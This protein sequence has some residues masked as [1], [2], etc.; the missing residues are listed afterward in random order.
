M[1]LFFHAIIPSLL[2]SLQ[3]LHAETFDIPNADFEADGEGWAIAAGGEVVPA[4]VTKNKDIA[5]HALSLPAGAFANVFLDIIPAKGTNYIATATLV[6]T[7]AALPSNGKLA[8]F[9]YRGGDSRYVAEAP[10]VWPGGNTPLVIRAEY[11]CAAEPE[12][13]WK[14]GVQILAQDRG[15]IAD[16]VHLESQPT[17]EPIRLEGKFG[18]IEV[19]PK[20]PAVRSLTLRREDGTLEPHSLFSPK[21]EPWQRGMMEWGTQA[22]TF[23]VD[24]AGKRFESRNSAPESVEKTDSSITLRGIVLSD[25][26]GEPVA[27][28]N[29]VLKT[30]GENFSWS[31]ERTW[32]RDMS[33]TSTGSP[34]LFFS[35]RP[36]SPSPSTIL[37]NSV[38]TSFWIN[39]NKLT[40]W[41]NPF[42]RS[43]AQPP[44]CKMSLTNNMVMTEPGGWAVLKLFPAWQNVTEPKFSAEAGHLYRRGHFGWLSEA[45]VVSHSNKKRVYK[46]GEIEMT[47]LTIT[48]VPAAASGH[49]LAVQ[50]DD[51]SGTISTI[52]QF[53]GS[54]FN[55]GAINDQINY[56]FGNET[57]GWYYGGASWMKGMP[58][59]SGT[60]A[61]SPTASAPHALPLAF[62]NNLQMIMGTEF[63]PGRTRFGYNAT[64]EYTD[65]NIIQIIGGRAYYLYSGDRAFVRQ[66][67]PFYRRAVAWYLAQRNPD[68][69][70]AL[71]GVSHWYYDAMYASGV[72]T[73]HNAFLYRALVDLAGLE[74]AV[75]NSA[76]AATYQANA[77]KLKDAINRVLWWE[78]APGGPRYVDWIQPDG[79]KIAYAAD[80][81][82]FPPVA[83]G[84][85][86]P[87][88]AKKL[89]A[90]I[91]RRIVE[92]ETENGYIGLASRS[93]YW[94]V[95]ASVNTHP[96]NQGFGN[97]MNGGSF[98]AMT[99]W[100]IMARAAAGDAEG[101]WNRLRKFAE[102]TKLTGQKGF[103]GNNWVFSDGRI[104]HSAC[105]EPYLSDAIA[106]PAALVQGILG[107]Q[108][109]NDAL[110]VKPALPAALQ[111]VT[112]EIVHLG[113]R[114]RVTVNGKDVQIKE[115]VRAFSPPEEITWKI[116]AGNSPEINL[117]IDRTFDSG[118]EWTATSEISLVQGSGISLKP[119]ATT[120]TYT[121]SPCDWGQAAKLI[122]I[123]SNAQLN[124]GSMTVRIETSDDGFKSVSGSQTIELRDGDNPF[125]NLTLQAHRQMRLALTLTAATAGLK[126]VLQ[127][128]ELAALPSK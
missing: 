61:E 98:L 36:T 4:P 106:V 46:A 48:P 84:I 47:T 63:E 90:T 49:Q 40:G 82:Q 50:A 34:A 104:G 17:V 119:D 101:A 15:L 85:A 56:N 32:L 30:K 10:A 19:D 120:G 117:Y 93:A 41:H 88:Q 25:G 114:K 22:Y 28:E 14:L 12:E 38:A 78:E 81:C 96:A 115:L 66:H 92:L 52:R 64:G 43:A 100:E 95:P 108:Q 83:F 127:S 72:T 33:T 68:G 54:L 44:E 39:P 126:P 94:P 58:F 29:W 65:D 60:P 11:A 86:S 42:Y 73:Y 121:T 97:Y 2:F 9:L 128:V 122:R 103:I 23:A 69:L 116:A 59:L 67:L 3:P 20:K 74:S 35:T 31:V 77:A 112:A 91:D 79:T 76:E 21:G 62:R 24:E 87:E 118:K 107:I 71:P 75:G 6:P 51:P 123:R 57:D 80:L 124:Q 27:R 111:K 102:G 37:P 16:A 113:I 55:G 45:G 109:T 1:K 70:V 13:G 53:Y 89:I 26:A 18:T 105:D 8:I 125:T 99:Y 7:Q 110:I 5:G